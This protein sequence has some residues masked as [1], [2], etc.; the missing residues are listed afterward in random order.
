[1]S[2][3]KRK[4]FNQCFDRGNVFVSFDPRR[5]GVK[6][7][8]HLKKEV[9]TC[10]VYGTLTYPIT[11]L[12]IGDNGVGAT[13]AFGEVRSYTFIPW[14]AVHTISGEDRKGKHWPEDAPTLP[15][16]G[17]A[18]ARRVLK[19]GRKLPNYIRVVK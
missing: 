17:K 15:A 18:H 13:L 16:P 4:I 8:E 3:E 12:Y 6:C 5:E 11:D 10:F 1:M 14:S 2:A 9:Q 7:P 19:N